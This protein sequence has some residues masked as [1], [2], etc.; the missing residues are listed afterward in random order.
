MALPFLMLRK[1]V[2]KTFG[3]VGLKGEGFCDTLLK[4]KGRDAMSKFYAEDN[5][6]NAALTKVFDLCV[7]NILTVIC[8][9]PIVTAGAAITAMYAVMLPMS[10]NKEGSISKSFFKE[11]RAN[12]KGSFGV[13]FFMLA[14]AVLFLFDLYVWTK[15]ESQY[16]SVFFGLTTAMLV[17]LV[18]IAGWYFALRATFV[19]TGKTS[20]IN[21][22]K[23][24]LIYLPA[25]ILMGV[26]TAAIVYVYLHQ[27]FIAMFIPVFGLVLIEYPKA[28][29]M[30]KKFNAYIEDHSDQYRVREEPEEEMQE[31]AEAQEKAEE[32]EEAKA[33]EEPEEQEEAKAVEE[34]EEQGEGKALEESEEQ[35]EEKAMEEPE[36]QGEGKTLE[37]P[38]EQEKVEEQAENKENE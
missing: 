6:F 12:L 36:E 16:R 21:A 14:L 28:C 31:E 9:L 22:G 20:L 13:W 1:S 18:V 33:V 35:E 32:Q 37:E 25:S 4:R 11:F 23:Y 34:P 19:D 2:H 15:V 30:R 26:Y 38:E 27:E 8:C 24:V 10:E 5:P 29:Y 3:I 7:L 17:A